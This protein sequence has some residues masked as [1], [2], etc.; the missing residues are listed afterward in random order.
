MV[1]WQLVLDHRE[2]LFNDDAA[3]IIEALDRLSRG[4]KLTGGTAKNWGGDEA[5]AT[6]KSHLKLIRTLC[7]GAVESIGSFG[8]EDLRA[9][10]L[11]P[12]W[13]E[14]ISAA[15]AAYKMLKKRRRVLDFDD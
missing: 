5:L 11:L 2:M 10:E 8:E 1:G 4:I 13:G 15:K 12:L 6:A 14:A 3:Q 9:A 7:E